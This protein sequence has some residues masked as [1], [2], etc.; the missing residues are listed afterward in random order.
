MVYHAIMHQATADVVTPFDGPVEEIPLSVAPLIAVVAQIRFPQIASITREEFIGDFQ[1]QIRKDYPVLRKESGVNFILTPDGVGTAG[2]PAT[3]WRFCDQPQEPAWTVSLAPSFVALDTSK[4]Q[5]RTDFLERLRSLLG[6]LHD[7]IAPST[8]D[9]IG[10]RYVN[11]ILLD[12]SDINLADLVREEVL[13]MTT[14]DPGRNA[15]L[16][17]SISD[18]EFSIGDAT[19]HGRWGR[20]PPGVQLDPLHGAAVD[21]PSWILDLDMYKNIV[22]SIDVNQIISIAE[23]FAKCIYRLFRWSVYP[24][25]IQRF[26]GTV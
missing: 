10:I 13:G 19:L 2:D 18:T 6:A 21:W 16:L 12:K 26:G 9:R 8:C 4:Y 1:E 11:R 14:V 5:S 17:H 20:I 15:K 23:D 25:F 22:G 7:T 3:T 24:D